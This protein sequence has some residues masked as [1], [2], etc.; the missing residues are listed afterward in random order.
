MCLLIGGLAVSA[1]A[2]PA[3]VAPVPQPTRTL[4]EVQPGPTVTVTKGQSEECV[5]VRELAVLINAAVAEYSHAQAP[6]TDKISAAQRALSDRD[7]KAL[8]Q[9][10]ADLTDIDEAA[11]ASLI[12]IVDLR[13]QL[14]LALKAC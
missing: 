11:T 14:T 2:E 5:R 10:D 7:F 6:L 9:A 8:N 3:P 4:Y 13:A 1:P 12:K